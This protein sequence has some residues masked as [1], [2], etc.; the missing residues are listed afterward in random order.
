MYVSCNYL[1][2]SVI[3]LTVE[4]PA[5]S[6]PHGTEK[7]TKRDRGVKWNGKLD[8][9]AE[10]CLIRPEPGLFRHDAAQK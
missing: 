1:R 10:A 3:R 6:N 5:W 4:D 9:G 7:D 8:L 2:I